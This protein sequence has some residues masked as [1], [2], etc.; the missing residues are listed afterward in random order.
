MVLAEILH[1]IYL[2][3]SCQQRTLLEEQ[4]EDVLTGC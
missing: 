2:L 1:F 4:N 3:G